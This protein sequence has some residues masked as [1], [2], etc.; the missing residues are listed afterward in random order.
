MNDDRPLQ[1]R[2]DALPP[3]KR[4]LL[5]RLAARDGAGGVPLPLG[6]VS[7]GVRPRAPQ[8]SRLPL[9]YAQERLWFVNEL[10]SGLPVYNEC[11]T[12]HFA[13]NLDERVLARAINEIVRGHEALRTTFQLVDGEPLQRVA[14]QLDLPLR[15]VDLRDRPAAER[16]ADAA[17]LA[18][19]EACQ[20]FQLATGPLLRA[21][22]LHLAPDCDDLVVSMHHIICDEWSSGVF[23][24][25]LT[26]L[27]DA[28]AAGRPSPLPELPIQ[29]PDFAVWQRAWLRGPELER[30]LGYW[31]D[32]LADLAALDLPYDHPRPSHPTFSGARVSFTIPREVY[33]ALR[34]LSRQE[35][36]TL[37]MTL[38]AAFNVLLARYCGQRDIAVGTPVANR[39][40]AELEGLIGFFVNTL[41]L[42]TRVDPRL[43]FRELLHRVR[44]TARG[45]YAHQDLPFEKLVA[46]LHP[47][48]D[49]ARNPLFQVLF[50]VFSTSG[51][52]QQESSSTILDSAAPH[53]SEVVETDMAKFDVRVDLSE[54]AQGLTGFIEYS[55]ALFD[56][57]TIARLVGHYQVLLRAIAAGADQS[58]ARLPLLTP[59]DERTLL[60][61]WNATSSAYPDASVTA[62][63]REQA[64]RTPNAVAVIGADRQLTYAELIGAADNL[65]RALHAH[66]VA[67]G[68]LVGLCA[69]RSVDTIVA[70][71][72]IV[73][74][75]CAC[76]PLDLGHP[77]DR[78]LRLLQY[79]NPPLV[80]GAARLVNSLPAIGGMTV[81]PLE[82]FELTSSD[83]RLDDPTCHVYA[84][85]LV[86]V[87]FT[88]GSTGVPK[89]VAMRHGAF[90][91]LVQWQRRHW[92]ARADARTAQFTALPFD[93]AF[94]EIFATV[95]CGGALVIIDDE[96]RR[97]PRRLLATLEEHHVERL[98]LPFVALQQLA[99]AANSAECDRLDLREVITAGEQL[100]ITDDIRAWFAHLGEGCALHNQYGPAETH[101]VTAYQLSGAP[102]R[103][104]ALPPIGRPVGNT[105]VYVLDESAQPV[106]IGFAGDLHL[107]GACLGRGYLHQPLTTAERLVPDPFGAPGG[108]LSRTG[109]RV[110]W[111]ADGQLEYLGRYDDQVKI[112]GFRVEPGEVESAL[113]NH[114]AVS[115]CAVV[116][117]DDPTGRRRLA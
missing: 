76:V 3:N 46:E 33:V 16:E 65:A 93:L 117:R 61:D 5:E 25:E 38:L 107:G 101:V 58:I 94:Q 75:G 6:S 37:F 54:S 64:Q 87:V 106:P 43:T 27:Y 89:G 95:A 115:P 104:P 34:A 88:S 52:D 83:S 51:A 21:M 71:L 14:G 96:A 23:T 80:L 29:Y 48:R 9:S 74:A 26:A 91:N 59:E 35:G 73:V 13:R 63:V 2:I 81:A 17:R 79:I 47:Q 90:S 44:E 12:F 4:A 92:S 56:Q 109:D 20:T 50:Q 85:E 105:R 57:A 62:L 8:L 82:S 70:T 66:G 15:V 116:A 24:A 31:R 19:E 111:R 102:E 112:R 30:Q 45:A 110:R 67:R 60:V 100:R 77:R 1:Q 7:G 55:T 10:Y 53:S 39:T 108:R 18:R 22:L 84:D 11:G 103:W 98:F 114:Q 72:G 113:A 78:V 42:R 36:A 32:Q 99:E 40:R 28:F 69:D 68:A 97:D 86:Y 41:V 49:P